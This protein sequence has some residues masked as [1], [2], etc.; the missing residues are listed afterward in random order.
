MWRV[1]RIASPL[2]R[3]HI[4]RTNWHS[5]LWGVKAAPNF[6]LSN[7]ERSQPDWQDSRVLMRSRDVL[8]PSNHVGLQNP[9][10]VG[11][12]EPHRAVR[13]KERMDVGV[14]LARGFGIQ[15]ILPVT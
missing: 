6:C 14:R 11:I 1:N 7:Q 9:R 13:R 8:K 2:Y 5:A 15:K 4:A 3:T 12:E 10:L